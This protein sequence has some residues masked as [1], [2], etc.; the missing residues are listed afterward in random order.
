MIS[1]KTYK[2]LNRLQPWRKTVNIKDL[3][4]DD[5]S[6]EAVV[7]AASQMV[8]RLRRAFPDPDNALEDIIAEF[9]DIDTTDKQ[10]L[11]LF[12][13]TL[14]SLYDWADSNRIWLG[15]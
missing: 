9:N 6:P 2:V 5:E 12:N 1:D 11:L 13:D 15:L 8:Q 4:G 7:R 10:P 3:L 14:D